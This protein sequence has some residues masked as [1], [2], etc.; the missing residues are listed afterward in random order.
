MTAPHLVIA[1][2]GTGGHMFPAQALAQE[3]LRRGWRVSLTTDDR[4]ARY[5]S[6]FPE[7]VARVP[8]RS[9]PFA[10]G[11]IAA[12][13]AAPVL[14]GMGVLET[15][16]W[17][18]RDPPAV[19]AGF[20]GYPSLPALSA[21]VISG[22]PRLIHEQNGV[23]GRVNRRFAPRV[24]LV[25]CGTWPLSNAPAGVDARH[26]GNP[27]RDAA[28]ALAGAAYT[29]PGEGPLNLLV[30][31]GSQGAS[32]LT[33]LLPE[34]IAGLPADLRARL[35]LTQQAREGEA[36]ALSAAYA[37]QGVPAEV[38]PF[39][40]DMPQRIAEAQLVVCRAGASTVAE[41][42]AIGRPS[43]L[44]PYPHAMDDHQTANARPLAEAG[45]ARL[46]VEAGLTPQALSA[47]IA[48][49]LGDPARAS[50]M[51]SAAA[52]LGRPDAAERLADLAQSVART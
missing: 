36:E 16:R 5:A 22:R 18:R 21:A 14:I 50:A 19:V 37:A 26:V 2:G 44:I 38:A 12:K 3:M 7:A 25:A 39:F 45:A 46:A 24:S 27:I 9:A 33:R 43:I 32:A 1:A 23:L 48:A 47:H 42:T 15:L 4:G 6:G 41:L 8:V 52:G 13:V 10:R 49:V 20:G 28:R 17:F 30:F 40:A 31:G 51:A 11:G 35:R 29:P 34:A